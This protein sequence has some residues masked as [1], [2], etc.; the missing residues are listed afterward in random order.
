[1]MVVGNVLKDPANNRLNREVEELGKYGNVKTLA[2]D[3]SEF[4]EIL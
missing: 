4:R 3:N 2:A 1:M